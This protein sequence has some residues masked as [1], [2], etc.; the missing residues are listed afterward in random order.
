MTKGSQTPPGS[1]DLTEL[2]AR[3]R[4]T[5]TEE[6]ADKPLEM[7]AP[8][9]QDFRASNGRRTREQG[10]RGEMRPTVTTRRLWRSALLGMAALS[11][12]CGVTPPREINERYLPLLTERRENYRVKPGDTVTVRFWDIFDEES[13]LREQTFLILPDGRSDP[14]FVNEFL[15]AGKTIAEIEAAVREHYMA[16][17]EA[18]EVVTQTG[19]RKPLEFSVLVEPAGEVVYVF[20]ELE[21]P[22]IP[23]DLRPGMTVQDAIARAGG[24]RITADSDDVILRRSFGHP[25]GRPQRYRIDLNDNAEEII[26]FPDDHIHVEKNLF[27]LIVAYLR[28]YIFGIFPSQLFSGAAFGAGI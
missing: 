2:P 24:I 4:P 8:G 25:P 7:I 16:A 26:L 23:I 22:V 18:E 6:T 9:L 1:E 13:R 28:E 20:G 14:F 10:Q 27:A 17:G 5:S 15:F 21:R 12:S 19:E 3:D 11:A